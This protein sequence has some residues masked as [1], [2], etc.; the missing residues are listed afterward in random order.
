[1]VTDNNIRNLHSSSHSNPSLQRKVFKIIASVLPVFVW[2]YI[3]GREKKK[4]RTCL[5]MWHTKLILGIFILYLE[6]IGGSD[7]MSR[8]YI[9]FSHGNNKISLWSQRAWILR[10]RRP[11]SLKLVRISTRI[12]SLVVRLPKLLLNFK[13]KSLCAGDIVHTKRVR[14]WSESSRA[15]HSVCLIE[16][17]MGDGFH[18]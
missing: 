3:Y 10:L 12:K 15:H 2:M 14:L 4:K 9:W 17:F 5:L 6:A 13:R 7:V 8:L 16:G 11:D 1:M 18:G